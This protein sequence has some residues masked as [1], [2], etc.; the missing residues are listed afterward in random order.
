VLGTLFPELAAMLGFDQSSKYHDLSTDEHTFAALDNA[1]KAGASLR[2][3]WALL[4]HDAGKA[5]EEATETGLLKAWF[6][7]K[8]DGRKHFYAQDGSLAED[9]M[10]TFNHEVLSERVWRQAADRMGVDKATREDVATLVRNHMVPA[11]SRGIAERTRRMR[12]QFGDELLRDLLLHRLCD[13]LG[14]D[15]SANKEHVNQIAQMES[16]R[17]AA[18]RDKIPTSVRDLQVNGRDAIAAGATGGAV[19][20]Q[21]LRALLDEVVV[22]GD[23]MAL[24]REWQLKRL[25]A[26]AGV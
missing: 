16:Y 13:L 15:G 12:V 7:G 21:V 1:V 26:L 6:V 22:R 18:E 20:G 2:V 9:G 8:S 11:K 4:F 24:S 14:K 25:E 5:F 23:E 17:A 10:P 3:R 19:T